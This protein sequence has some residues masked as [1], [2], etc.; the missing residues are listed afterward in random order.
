M[1]FASIDVETANSDLASI[2]QV[3]ITVVRSGEIVEVWSKLINPET[4]FD[5]INVSIHGIHSNTVSEAQ[6]FKEIYPEISSRLSGIVVSHTN[7][8]RVSI[9][10]ACE[11]HGK[12]MFQT[13]W[14]DSA[15]MVRR[16]W[17][18]D[19][20]RR[21]YGLANVA[22][23]LGIDFRHH[24]AGED[25]RVAAEIVL[26][27]CADTG[28]D[29]SEWLKLVTQPIYTES[30]R[31]KSI[32]RES[33]PEGVLHGETLVFTGALSITRRQAAD[34]AT[35]AGCHVQ[36][37]VTKKTTLIVVGDQDIRRLSNQDKSSKHRKAESMI[38]KGQLIRIL[39]ESDFRRLISEPYTISD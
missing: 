6:T 5:G 24:D 22:N 39:T 11:L 26:R 27:I 18:D 25:A 17:P 12:P 28:M 16:A 21:G 7:F 32:T 38:E 1:N 35:V 2:C 20:A 3:G 23:D 37:N 10:R 29:M 13:S 15:K 31:Q 34:L 4:Y 33:N 14:I 30:I 36:S 9:S 19:Y 8:D